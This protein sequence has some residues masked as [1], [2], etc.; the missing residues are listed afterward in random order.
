MDFFKI[1]LPNYNIKFDSETDYKFNSKQGK[2]NLASL[3]IEESKGYCMYCYTKVVIDNKNYGHLEHTIEQD[4]C[5]ELID[6]HY[7]LSLA[8][9]KCNLSHKRTQQKLRKIS[10]PSIICD[11]SSCKDKP[12]EHFFKAANS[13]LDNMVQNNLDKIIIKPRGVVQNNNNIINFYNLEYDILAFEF[14]PANNSSY[15]PESKAFIESHIKKFHLND[16]KFRT[17]EIAY[18]IEDIITYNKLPVKKR[19]N[20]LIAEIFIENMEELINNSIDYTS[21]MNRV[22]KIC[23]SIRKQMLL[24][25]SSIS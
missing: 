24:K 16:E 23:L 1:N 14:K 10:I 17:N 9:A 4:T 25:Y 13:Y 2:I 20:N 11:R 18:V 7:N 21:G 12:C 5:T 19:Y 6:C 22:I 3:L 8:C 15:I